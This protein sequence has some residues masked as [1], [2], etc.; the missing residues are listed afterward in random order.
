MI[1]C[2]TKCPA[3]R[4]ECWTFSITYQTMSDS[5]FDP[6]LHAAGKLSVA[7]VS[8]GNSIVI[9]CNSVQ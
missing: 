1:E 3:L 8:C 6:C 4:H 2:R 5:Y 7:S 9:K